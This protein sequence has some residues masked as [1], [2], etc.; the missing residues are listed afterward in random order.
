M[1]EPGKTMTPMGRTSSIWSLR[2]KGA[3]LRWRFQSGLKGDLR[4]LAIVGPA[5]GDA[6]GKKRDH[7]W[8]KVDRECRI[9]SMMARRGHRKLGAQRVGV[10]LKRFVHL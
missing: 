9:W 10:V 6:L 7:R 3:A 5:G 2:L 4:D 8:P 1:P